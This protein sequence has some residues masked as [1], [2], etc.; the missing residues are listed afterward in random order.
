MTHEEKQRILKDALDRAYLALEAHTDPASDSFTQLLRSI[1]ELE[2][3]LGAR[4]GD[5]DCGDFPNLEDPEPEKK[6]PVFTTEPRYPGHEPSASDEP[7]EAGAPDDV[8]AEPEPE[9]PETPTYKME[10]V[11]GALAAARRKGVN[12]SEIVHSFGVDNFAL[13]DKAKYPE[14]MAKLKEEGAL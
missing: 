12:V 9:K 1:N 6:K 13:I 4:L 3:S 11:R 7:V 2:F 5:P 10:E 14:I 8:P